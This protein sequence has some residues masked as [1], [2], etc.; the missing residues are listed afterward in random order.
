M[1]HG[2]KKV[3]FGDG[4]DANQML[5]RKLLKNFFAHGRITSTETKIKFLKGRIDAVVSLA[6]KNTQGSK[7][8]LLKILGDSD[9]VGELVNKVPGTLGDRT[10]GFTKSMRLFE[11]DSDGTML[12]RL[13]WVAPVVLFEEKAKKEAEKAQKAAVKAAGKT[14]T[15]KSGAKVTV[16][17]ARKAK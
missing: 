17:K 6:K 7:N 11:R 14:E 10:S 16:R 1:R 4:Q 2:Y 5:Q 3:R 8:S 12:M 13:E 15:T 9:L